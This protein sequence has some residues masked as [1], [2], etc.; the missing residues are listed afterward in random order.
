MTARQRG[1]RWIAHGEAQ[2]IESI[3]IKPRPGVRF[4][5]NGGQLCETAKMDGSTVANLARMMGVSVGEL[6]SR[7]GD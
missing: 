5:P 4:R 1:G 3:E 7:F 2:V 6:A